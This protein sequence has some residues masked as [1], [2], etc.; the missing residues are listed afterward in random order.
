MC[1]ILVGTKKNILQTELDL[2]WES[3]PHGAGYSYVHKNRVHI[4]KGFMRLNDLVESLERTNANGL[5]SLHLR[6]ATHGGVNAK[7]THPFVVGNDALAHNGILSAFGTGGARGSSDSADLARV[8]SR[9]APSDRGK[10]LESLSGMF[11]L[12]TARV[13]GGIQL[14][15]SRNWITHKNIQCSNDYWLP[16]GQTL[17]YP[18]SLSALES[19][20]EGWRLC[21]EI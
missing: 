20:W 19:E 1:V 3:N 8:L 13:H 18:R 5:I 21:K 17:N 12:T 9:L 14:F 4:A 2:A 16:R 15:G 7:N 11:A 6:V 10:I